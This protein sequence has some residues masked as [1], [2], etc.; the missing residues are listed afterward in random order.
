MADLP[1]FGARGGGW[2]ALQSAL[3]GLT[4]VACIAG[5]AWPGSARLWLKGAGVLLVFAGLVVAM[6]AARALGAGFTPFPEPKDAGALV[7]SG[8]YALVRHPVYSGGILFLAGIALAVS[9]WG[10]AGTAALA[11]L[12][13]LK[14]RV[15]ERLLAVRYPGYAAYRERTRFRLIPFVY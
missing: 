7:V 3:F 2:V 12:W 13:A 10:L 4:A 1:Q 9:P 11:V 15:E 5:P 14:A 6:S 8:P